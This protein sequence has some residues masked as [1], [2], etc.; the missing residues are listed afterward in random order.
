[1][2]ALLIMFFGA[3]WLCALTGFSFQSCNCY[4]DIL[5]MTVLLLAI[6]PKF[7]ILAMTKVKLTGCTVGL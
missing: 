4:V 3:A 7:Y 6:V 2:A 5:V 1:M